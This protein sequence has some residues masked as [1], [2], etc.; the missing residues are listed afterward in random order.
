MNTS[1]KQVQLEFIEWRANKKGRP[2]TPQE[3]RNKAINLLEH[4]RPADIA[5][6]LKINSSAL[7]NWKNPKNRRASKKNRSK[8]NPI[9]QKKSKKIQFVS[10]PPAPTVPSVD[11]TVEI[12]RQDG[13]KLSSSNPNSEMMEKLIGIFLGGV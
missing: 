6:S 5:K 2:H 3:L 9:G 7:K 12:I 13:V 4:H 11:S 1:L 10:L 8:L